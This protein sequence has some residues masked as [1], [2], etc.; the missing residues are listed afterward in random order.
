MPGRVTAASYGSDSRAP[1]INTD[2]SPVAMHEPIR[3][4]GH[5]LKHKKIAPLAVSE[6]IMDNQ[7]SGMRLLIIYLAKQ[8]Q[9]ELGEKFREMKF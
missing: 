6:T 1:T 7:L 3:H 5:S 2:I 8:N 9:C 4:L